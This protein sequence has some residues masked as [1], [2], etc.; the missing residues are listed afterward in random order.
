MGLYKKNSSIF[1]IHIPRTGGRYIDQLFQANEYESKFNHFDQLVGGIELPH[2][3]Y[4]LY[5]SVT[6]IKETP[7][8]F[9]VVRNP[10]E[11][12]KSTLQIIIKKRNYSNQIYE[13]LKDDSWAINFLIQEINVT[14]HFTNHFREQHE[15]ISNK[16]LIYKYE[17]GLGKNFV[18][19]LNDNFQLNLKIQSIQYQLITRESEKNNE[20]ISNNIDPIIKKIYSKDYEIFGYK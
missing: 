1:F 2:L 14:S 7:H 3:H 18:E 12:I 16:T 19:W 4:P 11:K 15:F 17:D 10:L 13:L 8:H 5:E 6:E 9:T 20:L